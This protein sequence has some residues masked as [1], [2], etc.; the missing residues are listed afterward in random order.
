MR[1]AS[2]S[3]SNAISGRARSPFCHGLTSAQAASSSGTAAAANNRTA[4]FIQRA[5]VDAE[6]A[7]DL[8]FEP[9]LVFD[10]KAD[11]RC[12]DGAVAPDEERRRHSFRRV[13]AGRIAAR[14]ER[15]R[16]LRRYLLEEFLGVAAPR[17]DVDAHDLQARRAIAREH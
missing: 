11:V 17:V 9:A 3:P 16:E 5:S 1:A 12:D 2:A 15:E 6:G 4:N 8:A 7:T 13:A 14:I 10:A